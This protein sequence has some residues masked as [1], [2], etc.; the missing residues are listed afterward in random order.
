[1]TGNDNAMEMNVER[2]VVDKLCRGNTMASRAAGTVAYVRWASTHSDA[3]IAVL[4]ISLSSTRKVG[5]ET[6]WARC[7]GVEVMKERAVVRFPAPGL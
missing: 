1:M 4:V 2:A 3:T 7:R 5:K 6:S